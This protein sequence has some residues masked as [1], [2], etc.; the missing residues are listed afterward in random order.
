MIEQF[1]VTAFKSLED[2]T[3][4]LGRVNVLIGPNGSG[5]SNF[6]EAL[7]VLGAAARGRVDDESLRRRGVRLGLPERYRTA[8]PDTPHVSEIRFEAT[9]D[10]ANY[11]VGL[12][13]DKASSIRRAWRYNYES[14]KEGETKHA[15][16]SQRSSP[17]LDPESGLAALKLVELKPKNP[18][19]LLMRLLEDYR[20]FA[21]TTPHLRGLVVDESGAR[22]VGL[23]GG[24]LAE[25]L[26]ELLKSKGG[27]FKQ[28]VL[29]LVEWATDV[30][31]T[32][33]REAMLSPSVPSPRTVV[34]FTDKYMK[35]RLNQLSAYDASEGALYIL[36]AAVLA[37]HPASPRILAIDNMDHA[38]NPRLARALMQH[39]CKWVLS[40]QQTQVLL[41]CQNP[42]TL[43]GLPLIDK[44]VRLF[45]VDRTTRGRTSITPIKVE[46]EILQK[47]REGWTLSRM[48][49]SGVLGG[50]PNV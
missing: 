40:R 19:Y 8:F 4:E 37:L 49:V 34:R 3:V 17:K 45:A 16:R 25:A 18:A 39:F 22:P 6:L 13:Q 11:L 21:P 7:G 5:K 47:A 20:I 33:A 30:D 24:N 12:W 1:H 43:D 46:D 35:K 42:T 38:L 44:R 26:E 41:T 29:E 2:V 27:S 31:I 9:S 15:S 14:L 23:S 50:V 32:S 36:F 28:R 10:E 48:W